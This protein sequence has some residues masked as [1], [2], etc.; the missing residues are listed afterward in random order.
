[1]LL[2]KCFMQMKFFLAIS[3]FLEKRKYIY[4]FLSLIISFISVSAREKSISVNQ[5]CLSCHSTGT[6]CEEKFK[7]NETSYNRP[8]SSF[9]REDKVILYK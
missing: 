6:T 5:K 8:I 9:A 1:M 7:I 4:L 3:L 2:A